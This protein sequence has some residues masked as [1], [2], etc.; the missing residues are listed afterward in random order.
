M[1]LEAA[2]LRPDERGRLNVDRNV[3]TEVQHV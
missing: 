2:G 3:R 1:A